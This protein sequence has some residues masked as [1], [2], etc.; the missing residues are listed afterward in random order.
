MARNAAVIDIDLGFD[1][2]IGDLLKADKYQLLIGIQ[3][4]AKTPGMVK[5]N[6]KQKAG[7]NVAQYAAEN[8]FGTTKIPQRSFMR[9][10]FDQNLKLIEAFTTDAIDRVIDGTSKLDTAFNEVGQFM[11]GLI[12]KKIR[13][14]TFPPNSKAT[15]A[16]KGSSKPLIDFG[17]M[18]ASVRHVLKKR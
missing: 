5:N 12:Q 17:T 3:E 8:E 14:I 9:T 15:I 7:L 4:G 11:T 10:A 13:Q 2:I 18:I 16:L 1:K 6:H